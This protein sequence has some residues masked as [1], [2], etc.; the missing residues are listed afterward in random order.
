M[1]ADL[2][3]NHRSR[4][5]T[6]RTRELGWEL[7]HARKRAKLKATALA[8]EWGWSPG[9]LSKLEHGW[10]GTSDWDY[11]TLLGRLGVDPKTR[12]RVQRMV[13]EQDTGH[14]LRTHDGLLSDNLRCLMIHERAA[15]TMCKYDPMLIPGLLQT[16][17]YAGAVINPDGGSTPDEQ[18][19]RIEARMDRQS[20]LAGDHSPEA[21]FFIHEIALRTVITCNQVMHDQ[22][23]HLAFLCKWA[24]VTIRVIPLSS[25]GHPALVNS[26]NLMTFAKSVGPVAY[27]ETDVAT[28]FADEPRS[29]EVC[30]RKQAALEAMS[31]DAEQSR[32]VLAR[33]A[34]AYDR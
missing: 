11:G 9:K 24:R 12:E 10:R 19:F 17:V 1:E 34:D 27:C 4:P 18:D 28:V 26:F 21:T 16:R 13:N 32:S 20:V 2:G 31:L 22:M 7:L 6:A 14:F 3:D 23:M 15:R 30:R 33:W 29:I 8:A 5:T 25:P